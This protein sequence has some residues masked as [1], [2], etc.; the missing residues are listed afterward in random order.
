MPKRIR[1]FIAVEISASVRSR[2]AALE[3]EFQ[4][5]AEN[6]KWVEPENIHLTLNFLGDVDEREL[7]AV[8]RTA[9]EVA[10]GHEPFEMAV[11][12]VGAFP[13]ARR[14]RVIWA[15]VTEGSRELTAIHDALADALDGQGYAREDRAYTPHLTLG[16]IRRT[17]PNP[18][19][20]V[21]IEQ[22]AAWD[23]GRSFVREI[24]VMASE[25]SPDGP[26]YTVMGRAPL[27]PEQRQSP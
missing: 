21:A 17:V 27:G 23:G 14:P 15:G 12:R 10:A 20:A 24:L 11:A 4:T 6:V 9:S 18:R 25:L 19:L 3:D 2:L 22:H 16:R 7:Y 8:C 13:N 1:T 26:H 5:A